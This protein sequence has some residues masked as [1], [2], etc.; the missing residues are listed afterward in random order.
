M[1]PALPPKV[2]VLMPVYN[3]ESYLAE[4]IRSILAQTFRDFELLIV[5]DAS[6]DNSMVIVHSFT[7]SRIRV[8]KNGKNLG[9]SAT[10]N[11][12]IEAAAAPLIARMDADDIS[13]PDRLEKQYGYLAAHPETAMVSGAVRVI[14]EEGKVIRIDDFAPEYYYYNLTF[15][16]WIYHPTVMYR[17]DAVLSVGGYTVTHSEDFELFWQLY[18]RYPC[19]VLKS[20][21]LD[22]RVTSQSL[23]MVKEKS[24]YETEQ[25][26]QV[27]RNINY[28]L[29]DGCSLSMEQIQALQNN[30]EPLLRQNDLRRMIDLVKKI[31]R[32]TAGVVAMENPNRVIPDVRQAGYF[33][34][35]FAI[36]AIAAQLHGLRRVAFLV[37]TGARDLLFPRLRSVFRSILQPRRQ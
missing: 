34:K 21:V 11:R 6:E 37:R 3:A 7:D 33:K 1:N 23:H 15:I 19:A 18:R 28:Y 12:G 20:L 31:D 29:S 30:F 14:D 24:G 16:C 8:L 35:R 27:Y 2:T 4:A 10:L 13:H 36:S 22:Y 32:I 9:I 5:D 25:R 17:R 26:K